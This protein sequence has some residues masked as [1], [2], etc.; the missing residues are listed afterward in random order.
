MRACGVDRDGRTLCHPRRPYHGAYIA[1]RVVSHAGCVV[2]LLCEVRL[3]VKRRELGC[4]AAGTIVDRLRSWNVRLTI[5]ALP[6][7][8]VEDIEKGNE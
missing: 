6:G 5:V 1:S 2:C 8:D 7:S 4:L 3:D